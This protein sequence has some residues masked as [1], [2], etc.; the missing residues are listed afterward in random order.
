MSSVEPALLARAASPS[1]DVN[2][3]A[4]FVVAYA[5]MIAGL[6]VFPVTLVAVAIACVTR[7]GCRETVWYSHG[8]WVVRTF[9]WQ[10][11]GYVLAGVIYIAYAAIVGF[12]VGPVAL[13]ANPGLLL[14]VA[15]WGWSIYRIVKGANALSEQR[16]I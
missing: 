15:V 6:F 13:I 12:I 3:K 4:P 14:A 1:R 16:A 11:L 7:R 10:L 5:V 2:H 8:C 9:W